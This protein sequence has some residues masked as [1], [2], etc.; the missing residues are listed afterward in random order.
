MATDQNEIMKAM[1]NAAV[2]AE[3]A[4]SA[5]Q[6]DAFRV[7]SQWWDQNFRRAGHKRLARVLLQYKEVRP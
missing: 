4:I 6:V 5:E 1:D 3:E 7:V 2:Q